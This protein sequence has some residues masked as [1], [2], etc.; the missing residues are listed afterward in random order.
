MQ[1]MELRFATRDKEDA[2]DYRYFADPD[3]TP[4]H[5]EDDFIEAIRQSIPALQEERVKKYTSVWQLS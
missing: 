2:D 3:L 4:F 1:I 5:L